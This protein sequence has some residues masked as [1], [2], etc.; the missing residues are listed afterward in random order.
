MKIA[1]IDDKITNIHLLQQMLEVLLPDKTE[2][3]QATTIQKGIE[4]IDACKP[5]LLFLDIDMG[6]GYGFEVLD[7][8]NFQ[9][10]E[11]VFVTAHPNF[12]LKSYAYNP[13]HYLLKPFTSNELQ[14]ALYRF[15]QRLVPSSKLKP[16]TAQSLDTNKKRICL[17][18]K[19]KLRF[20]DLLDIIY[21][22]SSNV[23]TIF[24]LWSKEQIIISKSLATYERT[25]PKPDFCRIHD[26]YLVNLRHV[27][28]Y[29]KGR[30]GEVELKDG[31][32]L[33]VSIRRKEIFISYMQKLAIR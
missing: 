10:F 25:L 13:I 22:E 7:Q 9:Q 31:T 28:S 26:R 33:S 17:P 12:A 24:H 4:L 23:Y 27:T 29:T 19:G 16:S 2:F 20:L 5:D 3:S 21:L 11:L 6:S 15:Q 18:E 8:C 30:G 32:L 14:E 1:I